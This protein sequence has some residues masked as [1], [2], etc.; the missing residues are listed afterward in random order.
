MRLAGPL[1]ALALACVLVE[2][3]EPQSGARA[4]VVFTAMCDASG[5]VP[6]T[7]SL[8]AV[9][10]DETNLLRVYDASRGGAPLQSSDVSAALGI[11]RPPSRK[12]PGVPRPPP[13]MDIEGA[14]RAG[15][16]AFW[17]T[18][19]GR[20][21]AGKLRPERLRFFASTAPPR[22]AP[23]EVVGA[24]YL[25]L[26]DDL[27]ADPRYARFGIPAAAQLPPKTE[28]GLN[29]EGLTARAEGGV[30]VGFR[31]PIPGGRALLV[32][33]LN[34]ERVIRGEPGRFGDPLL[35][36]LGG[37]GVRA[38]SRWRGRYL[39]V[40]GHFASGG[41]SRLYGWDGRSAPVR[42]LEFPGFNPEGAFSR[43]TR[44]E[45]LLLSDDG[46]VLVDGVECKQLADESR[47]SFRG[48]WLSVPAG[49]R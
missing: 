32:P 43:D 9:A 39:I 29:V 46:S 7:G 18:S 12:R 5:A 17:I 22:P 41:V 6:L 24:P 16:L 8:F 25:G 27:A 20:N 11:S 23:L 40:A 10:D 26:L 19:H 1:A 44:D 47:K 45:V 42:L 21:S 2:D 34:P 3:A 37:Y 14:T 30:F 31:S 33:F 35:L 38:L 49:R 4:D 36:D 48:R 15:E 13:E 28:G